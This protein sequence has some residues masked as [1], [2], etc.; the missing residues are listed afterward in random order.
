MNAVGASL[1]SARE[2]DSEAVRRA[3]FF[4]DRRE[5]VMAE[6]GDFLMPLDEG[7]ID[8]MHLRAE[9]GDLVSGAHAGRSAPAAITVFKSLGLAIE[10][11][12]ALRHIHT[13]ALATGRGISIELGG[14]RH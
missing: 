14:V 2:L 3:E 13:R 1:R 10:D 11:V 5:S 7:V 12:A 9:L 4:A 8:A 6:S